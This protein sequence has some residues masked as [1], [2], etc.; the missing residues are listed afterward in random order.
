MLNE[1]EMCEKYGILP[2]W[3]TAENWYNADQI[4]ESL[5]NV[6]ERYPHDFG[7]REFSE[8]VTHQYRLAM[9]KGIELANTKAVE[10]IKELEANIEILKGDIITLAQL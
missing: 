1:L 10:R 6:A 8:S 7:S 9:A 3:K 2:S 5:K 4:H